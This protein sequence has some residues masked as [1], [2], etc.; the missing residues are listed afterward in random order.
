MKPPKHRGQIP[1]VHLY[2]IN[3]LRKALEIAK[4]PDPPLM[5]IFTNRRYQHVVVA[6]L[7]PTY[8]DFI[9]YFNLPPKLLYRLRNLG[10]IHTQEG[11]IHSRWF[12]L[13]MAQSLSKH[14]HRIPWIWEDKFWK[15]VIP[16]Q[17]RMSLI[18]LALCPNYTGSSVPLTPQLKKVEAKARKIPDEVTEQVVEALAYCPEHPIF[19]FE[20][21]DKKAN[22]NLQRILKPGS[23]I[24]G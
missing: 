15:T 1:D 7:L 8:L 22:A 11:P 21:Q 5:E 20:I 17:A 10:V 13:K 3:L 6:G 16:R 24:R 19:C 2:Y 9:E 12:L 18:G 23:H 4:H 14:G